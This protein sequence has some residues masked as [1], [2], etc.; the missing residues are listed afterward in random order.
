MIFMIDFLNLSKYRKN[1]CIEAKKAQGGLPDSIGKTILGYLTDHPEAKAAEFVNYSGLGISRIGD[2]SKELV[3]KD[4][5]TA[6]GAN[7]NR[8]YML[9]S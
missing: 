6:E 4:V 2:Y 1:N 5:I 8:V 9:K 3:V 7:R